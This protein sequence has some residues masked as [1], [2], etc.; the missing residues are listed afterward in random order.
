MT[1]GASWTVAAVSGVWFAIPLAALF[2][3][4]VLLDAEVRAPRLGAATVGTPAL[5]PPTEMFEALMT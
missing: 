2:T 5:V 4:A 3:A 1:D